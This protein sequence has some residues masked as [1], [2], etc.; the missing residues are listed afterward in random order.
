MSAPPPGYNAGE[1]MLQG[2]TAEIVPVMGGGRIKQAMKNIRKKFSKKAAPKTNRTR[3]HKQSSKTLEQ[4][5]GA[6]HYTLDS[7]DEYKINNPSSLMKVNILSRG[8]PS[9]G[10]SIDSIKTATQHIFDYLGERGTVWRRGIRTPFLGLSEFKPN[11]PTMDNIGCSIGIAAAVARIVKKAPDRLCCFLPQNTSEIYILPAVNGDINLFL[12][13]AQFIKDTGN[14]PNKAFIFSSPFFGIKTSDNL[15]L[16][17]MF[18]HYKVTKAKEPTNWMFYIL[19]EYTTQNIEAAKEVAKEALAALK[20][21]AAAY[22]KLERDLTEQNRKDKN[23]A[24]KGIIT[25]LYSMLE[26]TY[27][28]YPYTVEFPLVQ[29]ESAESAAIREYKE[30]LAA[31]N[32][33]VTDKEAELTAAKSRVEKTEAEALAKGAAAWKI[34]GIATD[35]GKKLTN[36]RA[37]LEA[38]TKEL[39]SYQSAKELVA[40]GSQEDLEYSA[41]ITVT[42]ARLRKETGVVE[43]EQKAYN[44]K[45]AEYDNKNKEAEDAKTNAKEAVTAYKQAGSNLASAKTK[46]ENNKAKLEKPAALDS[47]SEEPVEEKG[48]LLFSAA[49]AGEP[50]LPEPYPGFDGAIKHIQTNNAIEKKRSIAYRVNTTK[51]ETLL[52]G[53]DYKEYKVFQAPLTDKEHVYT[54]NLSNNRPDIVV[55]MSDDLEAFIASPAVVQNHVPDVAISVGSQ[56]YSIRSPVPDVIDD[57]NNGIFSKDEANYLNAMTLSPKI[58]SKVFSISWKQELSNHLAMISRSKCFKDS[59]LLLHA[60]CQNAQSFVSKVLEYYMSHSGDIIETQRQQRNSEVKKLQAEL[61]AVRAQAQKTLTANQNVNIFDMLQFNETFY[62]PDETKK[63]G[64]DY[65]VSVN[66]ITVDFESTIFT[67]SQDP[68]DILSL[69]EQQAIGRQ[70]PEPD[71]LTIIGT[72][73]KFTKAQSAQIVTM[74]A[75][76]YLPTFT[77]TSKLSNTPITTVPPIVQVVYNG[78]LSSIEHDLIER[79][80]GTGF[81]EEA[82]M[83]ERYKWNLKEA[84]SPA[85]IQEKLNTINNTNKYNITFKQNET[86]DL[87][88]ASDSGFNILFKEDKI[89]KTVII[90]D[91]KDKTNLISGNLYMDYNIG[92][93]MHDA[94]NIFEDEDKKIHDLVN[95]TPGKDPVFGG[96]Y[97]IY[98]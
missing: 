55:Q 32:K 56:E 4:D 74:I 90:I 40:A 88:D 67:V 97:L 75:R 85:V 83:F 66:P 89:F 1:S 96:R 24:D 28:I 20:K 73:W 10:P 47:S 13:I 70:L 51:R 35:F 52:D 57:W 94:G 50:V 15:K 78:K 26:P 12:R 45:K 43:N 17:S 2:G 54:F 38:T 39:T 60:D 36:S 79:T 14:S 27:I 37:A 44:A 31:I 80:I 25:S 65:L 98:P 63:A 95:G 46:A 82:E 18:L 92:K 7:V 87:E 21:D 33:T 48:G 69:A 93:S 22:S 62:S 86:V 9:T 77:I 5:G 58:L 61:N 59:R 16:F 71:T 81:T 30:K 53:M 42:E 19:T 3:K 34:S 8:L 29:A 64:I 49:T 23:C 76:K 91:G 68:K 11:L 84:I 6:N 41:K 72:S